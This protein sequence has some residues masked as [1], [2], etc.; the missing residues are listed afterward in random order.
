M[1]ANGAAAFCGLIRRQLARILIISCASLVGGEATAAD[2]SGN[3]ALRVGIGFIELLSA[4]FEFGDARALYA[5]VF[6]YQFQRADFG[7]RLGYPVALNRSTN[8]LFQLRL[9]EVFFRTQT[10]CTWGERSTC[11]PSGAF[12]LGSQLVLSR[13]NLQPIIPQWGVAVE[14]ACWSDTLGLQSFPGFRLTGGVAF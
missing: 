14:G 4:E 9:P 8:W 7:V 6:F 11:S 2:R 12:G 1:K 13:Q 3:V 5:S 10:S